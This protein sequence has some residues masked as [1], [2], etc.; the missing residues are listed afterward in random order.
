M[1]SPRFARWLLAR[2]APSGREEEVV[3]DLEEAHLLRERRVGRTRALA[4]TMIETLDIAAT[5]LRGRLGSGST[6]SWL[7]L[8][9]ATRMLVRH[10]GLTLLGGLSMAFAISARFIVRPEAE[11]ELDEAA[12]WYSGRSRGLGAEF[13][14]VVDAAFSVIQ[15]SPLQFPQVHGSAE[16]RRSTDRKF[17]GPFGA[18][19]EVG[20]GRG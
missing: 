5:L 11:A 1:R 17:K 2:L 15:R 13:V 10:P 18:G 3:G 20:R 14:R 19:G 4:W 12:A 7:D 9:L 6:V 16:G 8:K